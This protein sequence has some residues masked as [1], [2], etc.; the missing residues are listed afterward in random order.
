[1]TVKITKLTMFRNKFSKVGRVANDNI[2]ALQREN[3]GRDIYQKRLQNGKI[4]LL[5]S[6]KNNS[7]FFIV[8]TNGIVAAAKTENTNDFVGKLYNRVKVFYDEMEIAIRKIQQSSVKNLKNGK[9]EEVSLRKWNI[10][11]PVDIIVK[12]KAGR[13]SQF[14][15]TRIA[16]NIHPAVAQKSELSNG[17]TVYWEHYSM[18]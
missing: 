16:K 12:S 10:D 2:T 18:S 9:I 8:G 14:P 1:M 13:Q 11:G 7:D 4:G 3:P 5:L 17:D 15:V 6:E